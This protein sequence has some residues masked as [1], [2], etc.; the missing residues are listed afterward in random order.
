MLSRETFEAELFTRLGREYR[1]RFSD[2]KKTWLIE[3]HVGRGSFE[4]PDTHDSDAAIRVRD[5]YA[6]VLESQTRS[7]IPCR[8]CGGALV[9]PVMRTMEVPCKSCELLYGKAT[10]H[11]LGYYPLSE[12]LLVKLESTSPKRG[13]AWAQEMKLANARLRQSALRDHDNY[14]EAVARDWFPRIADI[15]QVGFGGSITSKVH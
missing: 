12:G 5:G 13:M 4:T 14:T 7:V 8:V 9:V 2:F 1:L 11:F 6:L 15:P 3:Q 10:R